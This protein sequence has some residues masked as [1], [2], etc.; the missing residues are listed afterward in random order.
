[1]AIGSK[2]A[3]ARLSPRLDH[4]CTTRPG[5]FRFTD[6]TVA[7]PDCLDAAIP[8]SGFPDRWPSLVRVVLEPID[9]HS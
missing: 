4:T 2:G 7:A 8:S 5:D 3:A 9:E 1:M 6:T